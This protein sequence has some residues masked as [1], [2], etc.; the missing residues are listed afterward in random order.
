MTPW[1]R[2]FWPAP[3]PALAD[4]GIHGEVVVAR[5]LPSNTQT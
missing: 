2:R 1:W 4:A 5:G 3:N